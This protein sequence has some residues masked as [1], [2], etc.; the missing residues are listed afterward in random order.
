VENDELFDL[1]NLCDELEMGLEVSGEQEE[2]FSGDRDTAV[3]TVKFNPI[4]GCEK[5]LFN[6]S[7]TGK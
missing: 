1:E 2:L 6:A 5:Y 7:S 4:C 3:S